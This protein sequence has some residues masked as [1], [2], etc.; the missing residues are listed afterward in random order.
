MLP[1]SYLLRNLLRRRTRSLV[2]L[3]G[4]AAVTLLV[5]AMIAFA[6]GIAKTT[7]GQEDL[8]VL[9]GAAAEVDLVRSVIP[10]GS[11]E[12]AAAAAPG[13]AQVDGRRAASV[14]LHIASRTGNQVALLRGVTDAAWLVHRDVQVV[15][16]REPRASF[17]LMVG[18]LAHTRLGL[19]AAEL[20]P[21]KTIELER[22]DFT[23]V[24][25]FAAPGS[26]YEAEIWGRLEDIMLATK[27]EDVSCVVVRTDTPNAIDE[28]RLF[29]G[30]RLDLEIA[31]MPAPELLQ[32]LQQSLQPIT[33]LAGWMAI[34]AVIAGAFAC[35]NTMFAAVLARTRELATL[36]SLGYTPFAVATGLLVESSL[37]AVCGGAIGLLI[38][39][40]IGDVA[41][42]Y[43]MGA[44]VLT[45]DPI[46][47]ML[48][49]LAAFLSGLLGG[50][51]PA[52]RAVRLP[53][54]EAI[55]GRT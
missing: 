26:V 22:R 52:A 55:G 4:I 11:A 30:R 27:R 2:T 18:P 10:R 44:L 1:P 21:G 9:L 7:T 46:S 48:G 47:R 16:G 8:V 43:P 20:A 38:A 6:R 24:G 14:E 5:I 53:L 17:E 40:A 41:L 13:V 34:L 23:I 35:A 54:V 50:I 32:S 39:S 51:V 36:R 42:R 28:L 15:A 12:T 49:L 31:A 19:P 37:L 25:R 33:T 29:A 3:F 45:A